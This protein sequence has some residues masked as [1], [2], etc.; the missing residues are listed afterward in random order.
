MLTFKF[1]RYLE[2]DSTR[3][4]LIKNSQTNN[5]IYETP[6]FLVVAAGT[7]IY[8]KWRGTDAIKRLSA[9]LDDNRSIEREY[10]HFHGHFTLIAADKNGNRLSIITDRSGLQ[11]SFMTEQDGAVALSSSQLLLAS[12]SLSSLDANAVREFIHIGRCL[13]R[14]TLFKNIQ[15]M[16]AATALVR[17]N[18]KWK[19]Q[20]LWKIHVETPCLPDRY[21]QVVEKSW[22]M[23]NSAISIASTVAPGRL[24]ADL[25]AGTDSRLVLSFLLGVQPKL[26]VSATGVADHID[27]VRSK[28]IAETLGL[29]HFWDDLKSCPRCTEVILD[30]A[31]ELADG[32]MDFSHVLQKLGY[33]HDKARDFDMSFGGDGGASFKDHYWLFEF[34]RTG[35]QRE[36]NWHRI[37][38][39]H[40]VNYVVQD[41]FFIGFDNGILTDVGNIWAEHSRSVQ[42]TNN[43][44]I[45]YVNLDLKYPDAAG[46]QVTLSN[47]F[48][49]AYHPLLEGRIVEYMMNIDPAIR[50]YNILQFSL[51]YRNNPRLAWMLTDAGVPAVPPV[52]VF[53]PLKALVLRRYAR[54]GF[55]KL[56]NFVL[57]RPDRTGSRPVA[58]VADALRAAGYFDL[59]DYG[60]L[61]ITP[62]ISR[63]RLSAMR[64]RPK[65]GSNNIYLLNALAVELFVKR[66]EELAG[67]PIEKL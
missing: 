60:K 65:E 13:Q 2:I 23:L 3:V 45:D 38:K 34:N 17:E 28:K 42:G 10:G 6:T 27:V 31:V 25:T 50:K 26:T 51:I 16:P 53:A 36:P 63:P 44:K 8:G 5:Y 32:G 14:K 7:F 55:R 43:Q 41:D 57:R 24:V 52:G 54:S 64:D 59:L 67:R 4:Y 49:D 19:S 48:H 46:V 18:G 56:N 9:E 20:R 22:E 35:L 12:V 40:L 15:R 21:P 47:K 61:A 37:A 58:P 62:I 30:E 29:D 33:L 1:Y 66:V 11:H 39:L